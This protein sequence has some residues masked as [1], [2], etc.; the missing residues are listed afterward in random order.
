MSLFVGLCLVLAACRDEPVA[1]RPAR[2]AMPAADAVQG[3]W[4]S[5]AASTPVIGNPVS[6]TTGRDCARNQPSDVWFLAGTF[7]G[8][9]HRRCTV[10]ARRPLIFPVVNVLAD[11]RTCARFMA[12]AQGTVTLDGKP[13]TPERIEG[14]GVRVTAVEH[15][16][17]T[18]SAGT[19]LT[20]ACGLWVRHE[21]LP[22][23]RHTLTVRGSTGGFRTVA[24]YDL[25]VAGES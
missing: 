5:W 6:D 20:H 21:P 15:N 10:P 13:V 11:R 25:V 19:F 14:D 1:R 7:G 3:R 2:P 16:P 18:T 8:R 9:V 24:E 4:W 22:P 17:V 12:G 23:G